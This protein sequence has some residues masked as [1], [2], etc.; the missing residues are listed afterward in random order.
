MC[1]NKSEYYFQFVYRIIFY[2]TIIPFSIMLFCIISVYRKLKGLK[3]RLR[4]SDANRESHL[5]KTLIGINVFFFVINAPFNLVLIYVSYVNLSELPSQMNL[6]IFNLAG[7]FCSIHTSFS[8]FVYLISNKMFRRQFF[9][10][11]RIRKI[12]ERYA[13]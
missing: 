4:K 10:I 2:N 13:K 3:T 5:L 1:S 12:S 11:F 7:T 9:E 8:F 6:L